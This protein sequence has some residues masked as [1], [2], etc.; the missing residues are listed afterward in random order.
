[1][2]DTKSGFPST[3][4]FRFFAEI[5]FT[6]DSHRFRLQL[7]RGTT[8]FPLFPLTSLFCQSVSR[9][10]L[11]T[12]INARHPPKKNGAPLNRLVLLEGQFLRSPIGGS[13]RAI[14]DRR[15]NQAFLRSRKSAFSIPTFSIEQSHPCIPSK[16]S[17][18]STGCAD[19]IAR[20]KKFLK[21]TASLTTP[22]NT[23]SHPTTAPML[24]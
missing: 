8:F 9:F 18:F 11:E 14:S 15:P 13:K 10:F 21:P 20:S 22:E 1:M 19:R 7:K 3:F 4:F 6:R 17:T 23:R 2:R 12:S 5:V 24:A 16:K